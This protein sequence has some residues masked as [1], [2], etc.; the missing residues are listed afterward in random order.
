MKDKGFGRI[1]YEKKLDSKAGLWYLKFMI[2][3]AA[4]C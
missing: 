2:G 4:N 1:D 3:F